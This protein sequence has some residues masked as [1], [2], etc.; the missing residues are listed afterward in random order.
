MFH[1]RI[2]TV[3]VLARKFS[4]VGIAALLLTIVAAQRGFAQQGYE[5]GDF[6][7][8][9]PIIGGANGPTFTATVADPPHTSTNTDNSVN[10][11]GMWSDAGDIQRQYFSA[12]LY[13]QSLVSEGATHGS[14]AILTTGMQADGGYRG[15]LQLD[16]EGTSPTT[17]A[18]MH[19]SAM[20]FDVTFDP[21]L[22]PISNPNSNDYAFIV[23]QMQTQ[24][25]FF[26]AKPSYD[27][28]SV[29]DAS[30]NIT[31]QRN[32]NPGQWNTGDT[33]DFPTGQ[34]VTETVTVD[35]TKDRP[36]AAGGGPN[37]TTPDTSDVPTW[38]TIHNSMVAAYN[39]NGAASDFSN[40]HI[41]LSPGNG[42]STAG[43]IVDNIRFIEPGDFNQ[44]GHVDASDLAL[45]EKALTN[46][47]A[48]ETQFN[49]TGGT[50]DQDFKL[51]ADVNGDGVVNLFDL[52]ALV[53][54]IK[55]GTLNPVPEPTTLA[56]LGIGGTLFVA[57]YRKRKKLAA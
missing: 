43:F 47:S 9:S 49:M 38:N 25:G 20:K 15:A 55:N 31:T 50:K 52:Q 32:Y 57:T 5:I 28:F 36:N 19:A 44:D 3:S 16:S 10:Y 11:Y 12:D 27:S 7:S 6:E 24:A 48:Y 35:F 30:G 54:G 17:T 23:L 42:L 18:L 56:L 53:L 40:I 33:T 37:P 45:A 14:K 51:V 39:T 29:M 26:Q 4:F 46:P 21:A 8:V 2:R 22:L 1:P 34:T 13:N 41:D